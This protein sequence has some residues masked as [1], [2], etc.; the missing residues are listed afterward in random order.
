MEPA[1]L[2]VHIVLNVLADHVVEGRV[3]GEAQGAGG[4]PA[5]SYRC[6]GSPGPARR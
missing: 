5:R 6:A 1:A 4:R 3:F 2:H